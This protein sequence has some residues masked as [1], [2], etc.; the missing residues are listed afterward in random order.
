M[1]GVKTSGDSFALTLREQL[2]KPSTGKHH[3]GLTTRGLRAEGRGVANHRHVEA[4]S[5]VSVM[6]YFV[7]HGGVLEL[8]AGLQEGRAASLSALSLPSNILL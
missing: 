6:D 5:Q 8:V 7:R 3:R 4:V 2:V 1:Q